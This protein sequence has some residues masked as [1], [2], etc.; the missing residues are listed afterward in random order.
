[1]KSDDAEKTIRMALE[2]ANL[3]EY[4]RLKLLSD[5]G[6]CYL[7]GKLHEFL[8]NN[9]IKQITG[10]PH[11]SQTQWKIERYHRS[12]KNLIK[13]ENYYKTEQLRQKIKEFV[14][15]FNY[16]KNSNLCFIL[17]HPVISFHIEITVGNHRF[18]S[19]TGISVIFVI[20]L[21]LTYIMEEHRKSLKEE[22]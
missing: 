12:M 5:N 15:Y 19:R 4:Q 14:E 1:M 2:N 8:K 22:K 16:R 18:S 7:S 6:K 3:T 13:L 11:H 21:R 9:D 20:V 17:L 10:A